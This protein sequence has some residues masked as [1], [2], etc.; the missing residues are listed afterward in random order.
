MTDFDFPFRHTS[1]TQLYSKLDDRELDVRGLKCSD[2][3]SS[4]AARYLRARRDN[5]DQTGI[6]SNEMPFGKRIRVRMAKMKL[7]DESMIACVL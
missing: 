1:T 6:N 4:V 3:G 7:E 2:C 5:L